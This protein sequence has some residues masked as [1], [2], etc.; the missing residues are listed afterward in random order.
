MDNIAGSLGQAPEF[1]QQRQ[2]KHFFAADPAYGAGIAKRLGVV[3]EA[4]AAE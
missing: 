1:I 4:V 2:L 3:A